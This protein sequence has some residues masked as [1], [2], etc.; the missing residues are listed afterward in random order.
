[1]TTTM[2]RV[3]VSWILQNATA[4]LDIIARDADGGLDWFAILAGKVSHAHFDKLADDIMTEGFTLPIVLV[5][6]GD[7]KFTIGNGHHRLSAAILLGLDE[8]P[9]ILDYDGDFWRI[10]DSHDGEWDCGDRSYEYWELLSQNMPD[11]YY[12]DTGNEDHREQFAGYDSAVAFEGYYCE[13]CAGWVGCDCCEHYCP[14]PQC[15]E[16]GGDL[17]LCICETVTPLAL[18]LDEFAYMHCQDCNGFGYRINHASCG[19]ER[20]H[21]EALIVASERHANGLDVPA[22]VWHPAGVLADAYEEHSRWLADEPLRRARAEWERALNRLRDACADGCSDM[23]V[24]L[25][26]RAVAA[27]WNEYQAL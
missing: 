15:E 25:L 5:A 1:M 4:S 8:I 3:S 6:N 23:L 27:R 7:A 22:G 16:C 9:V 10:E 19:M 12:G 14:V 17:E 26:A 2:T 21:A 18:G 24:N 13:E 20:A 11:G